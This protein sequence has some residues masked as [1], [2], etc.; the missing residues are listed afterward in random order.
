MPSQQL[1]QAS[2]AQQPQQQP[3]GM[4]PQNDPRMSAAMDV[5]ESNIPEYL[6]PTDALMKRNQAA[7]L[8]QQAMALMASADR[9]TAMSQQPPTPPTI[10]EQVDQRAM[11]GISGIA[12]RLA[13]GMQQRGQQIQKAQARKMLSGGM[14]AMGAPNMARMADGGIIGYQRGGDV[15]APPVP[16]P[17]VVPKSAVGDAQI[18]QFAAEYMAIKG[19]IDNAQTPEGKMQA[20]QLLQDLRA[21]MGNE[22]GAVMQYIDSTQGSIAAPGMARGGIIGYQQGGKIDEE[23]LALV[24]PPKGDEVFRPSYPS[25]DD[26]IAERER[27]E[28]VRAANR[29]NRNDEFDV[30]RQLAA[31]GYD[32]AAQDKYIEDQKAKR[33]GASADFRESIGL[34]A[35]LAPEEPFRMQGT[36]NPPEFRM[37][38][39]NNPSALTA[40]EYRP[41]L[42]GPLPVGGMGGEAVGT[43]ETP[44]VTPAT[45]PAAPQEFT[46]DALDLLTEKKLKD[47]L[48]ADPD[49]AATTRGDRL[50]ELTG[51]D[52]LMA[53]RIESEKAV[54]AQKESRLTPEETR[55]R[56]VREGLARLAEQ[57]LGGFGAGRT[58]EMDKIAAERLGIEETSLADLN[59]LIAEKRAMGMTQFEAE[60][61]ARA[62]IQGT[63]DNAATAAAR[64]RDARL[65][66]FATSQEKG[67]DRA[68]TATQN[69][70]NRESNLDIAELNALRPTDFMNEIKIRVEALQAGTPGLS[71]VDAR[72]QALEARIEA[73]ARAQL[74]AAGI[75]A[76]SLELD[77]LKAAYSM[78]GTKLA[79]R[80]DLTTNPEAFNTAF[81]EEVKNIMAEFGAIGSSTYP[82]MPTERSQLVRG[83]TYST[84]QGNARWNGTNFIPVN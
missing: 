29:T 78:A 61:S 65:A 24:K 5:V 56:R 33:L 82:P 16:T 71:G 84:S 12:Q 2:P 68:A 10:A 43:T 52:D 3:Q 70:L 35:L 76:D 21:Q 7:E 41:E 1:Q 28:A 69:R 17:G 20:Q 32:R 57:G 31:L 9:Q 59:S 30:R 63:Q 11:E 72:S 58:A 54:R 77:R 44:V 60:N 34:N 19:S 80:F 39:T 49:T 46:P 75:R 48:N 62:E 22:Q 23:L 36:N 74:A 81:K 83:T 26:R 13:P 25:R 27:N 50:R 38:G 51:F 4:P 15:S 67:L 47:A 42:D 55:K 79:N 66:A 45:A 8:A 6:N 18:K 14:P 37:Q 53:R 73:Q 40:T 64:R